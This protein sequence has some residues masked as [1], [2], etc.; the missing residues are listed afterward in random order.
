MGV[1]K[2][3]GPPSARKSWYVCFLLVVVGVAETLSALTSFFLSLSSVDDDDD[4]DDTSS[5]DPPDAA[6]AADENRGD[7]AA[8]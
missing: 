7:I 4:D 8:G 2:V 3:R 5:L 6:A 1:L